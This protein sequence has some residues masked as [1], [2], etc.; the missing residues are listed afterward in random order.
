[1]SGPW[2]DPRWGEEADDPSRAQGEGPRGS[3]ERP[4]R[5]V[6]ARGVLL[7]A[8]ALV[9]GV[10]L[11]PSAT[12]APLAVGATQ[13]AKTAQTT[14]VHSPSKKSKTSTSTT[15]PAP[16]PSSIHVLV[17]NATQVDGVAGA[18]TTFLGG[19]G[20][21]TLTAVNATTALSSSQIFYTAAGSVPDADEV[22]SALSLAASTIQGAGATPPVQSAAGASVVVIAGS[23]LAARFVPSSSSTTAG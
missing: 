20:F 4:Q 16:A 2:D 23:D 5:S 18:V 7:V 17:A 12:R 1:M 15:A 11:L 8:V 9:I 21:A 13:T 10:L 6:A 14:P 3:F 19:K 22:A